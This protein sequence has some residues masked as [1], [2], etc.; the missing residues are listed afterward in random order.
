MWELTQMTAKKVYQTTPP[1]MIFNSRL[2]KKMLSMLWHVK[3]E[4]SGVNNTM[5]AWASARILTAHVYMQKDT[6]VNYIKR[7]TGE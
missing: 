5:K 6:G 1:E 2:L 4:K 3:H 7:A